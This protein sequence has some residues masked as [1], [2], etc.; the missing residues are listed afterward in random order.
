MDYHKKIIEKFKELHIQIENLPFGN[1]KRIATTDYIE[2]LSN[3]RKN[4]DHE[5]TLEELN[6]LTIFIETW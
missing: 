6:Y 2:I 3:Y 5:K 1:K 4:R